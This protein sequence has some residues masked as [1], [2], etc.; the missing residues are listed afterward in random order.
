MWTAVG[1]L[2]SNNQQNNAAH[3]AGVSQGRISQA[4]VVLEY[5]PKLVDPVMLYG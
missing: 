3:D 5:Q 4:N 2:E 1:L